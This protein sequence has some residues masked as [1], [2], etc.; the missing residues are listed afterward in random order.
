MFTAWWYNVRQ[1]IGY[2]NFLARLY[3][4][5][6]RAQKFDIGQAFVWRKVYPIRRFFFPFSGKPDET[7]PPKNPSRYVP[8]DVPDP[9]KSTL[10]A[11]MLGKE[12][13]MLLNTWNKINL[14]VLGREMYLC[15]T[16][17]STCIVSLQVLCIRRMFS[18]VSMCGQC[19]AQATT[20]PS[21][22]LPCGRSCRAALM[23]LFTLSGLERPIF[24][25]VD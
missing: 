5:L 24:W 17:V 13:S 7:P 12:T 10:D 6:H 19:P 4:Y 2:Q 25:K 3:R 18:V 8:G 22:S 21:W 11:I 16:C 1:Y 14:P 23:Q 15:D 20:L 9:C